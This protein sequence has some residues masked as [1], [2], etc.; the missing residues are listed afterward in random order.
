[1]SVR[2]KVKDGRKVLRIDL[3]EQDE[4][5]TTEVLDLVKELR[6]YLG[7][8]NVA[9]AKAYLRPGKGAKLVLGGRLVMLRET[10]EDG[11][12]RMN[13]FVQPT[14]P[15]VSASDMP[16]DP[17]GEVAAQLHELFFELIDELNSQT[18]AAGG[19]EPITDSM[20]ANAR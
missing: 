9:G 7:Q 2:A 20:L 5:I 10:D 12:L 15:M 1:M 18:T 13:Y 14:G 11:G 3:E 4:P 19:I 6:T 8:N 17:I 16:Q